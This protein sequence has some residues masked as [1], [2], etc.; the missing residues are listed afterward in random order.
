[1]KMEV[2]ILLEVL[3]KLYKITYFCTS[4]VGIF[5]IWFLEHFCEENIV[6][7]TLYV[8]TANVARSIFP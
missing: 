8:G 4:E 6:V 2:A 5:S 1:L 3:V 7:T